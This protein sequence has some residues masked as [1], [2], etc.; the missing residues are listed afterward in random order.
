[1]IKLV[2][3]Y[4]NGETIWEPEPTT[5]INPSES[6]SENTS[7]TSSMDWILYGLSI[8]A[9]TIAEKNRLNKNLKH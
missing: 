5:Q 8:V 6:I 7:E 1:V 4:R 9:L 2:P 3:T